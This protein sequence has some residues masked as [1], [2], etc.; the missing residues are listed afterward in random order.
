M[1]RACL[2]GH[3]DMLEIFLCHGCSSNLPTSHGR[4]I[5]TV[6]TALKAHRWLV[7]N[8]SALSTIRLLL[9]RDCDV[10]VKNYQGKSPLL[11]AAELADGP[12]LAEILPRCLP[13]QLMCS[14]RSNG[15]TPLHMAC[16]NGSVECVRRLLEW[17]PEGEDIDVGDCLNLSPLL[18][19]MMVLKNNA[20]IFHRKDGVRDEK[21]LRVQYS[22]MA[23]VE[24][25]L[26]RGALPTKSLIPSTV[27]SGRQSATSASTAVMANSLSYAPTCRSAL[28]TALEVA[29]HYEVYGVIIRNRLG[30]LDP[31]LEEAV[32]TPYREI[33]RMLVH[34]CELSPFTENEMQVWAN[35]HPYIKSLMRE[36]NSYIIWKTEAGNNAPR[37][38]SLCRD[39]IRLQAAKS[40]NLSKLELLPIPRKLKDYVRFIDL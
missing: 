19:S 38:L 2:L 33:V 5:H 23:I 9:A 31:A 25:L 28:Q 36:I 4:L 40:D 34:K 21:L 3:L 22:H 32:S 13:W 12:I 14:E 27:P 7:D 26:N 35:A 39:S 11:L 29:H 1:E 15:H 6:L 16:M 17:I 18:C 20:I 37:L 24:M 10:N 30:Q 8:G